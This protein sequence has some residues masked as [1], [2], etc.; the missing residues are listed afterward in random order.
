VWATTI[1]DGL[2]INSGTFQTPLQLLGNLQVA[3]SSILGATIMRT[4]AVINVAWSTSDNDPNIVFGFIVSDVG[5]AG[6]NAQNP[7]VSAGWGVD[8]MLW[9]AFMPSQSPSVVTAG[10]SWLAG[11]EI[12]LRSKRKVE[13]LGDA[14]FF[15]CSNGGSAQVTVDVFARILIALP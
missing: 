13:E 4:H 15:C 10:T 2:A 6:G 3:G 7:I 9:K 14:Y 12:D 1:Q 8:W 5:V 11:T